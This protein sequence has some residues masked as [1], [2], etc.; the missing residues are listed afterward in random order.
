MKRIGLLPVVLC[1]QACLLFF[2]LDLL[3]VWT[4]ELFTLRT[5]AHPVAEIVPIVQHDIHPPLYYVLLHFWQ[6]LMPAESGVAPLRAFSVVWALLGTVLLDLFWAKKLKPLERSLAL[7][8]FALSPCLLLYGR[9]ARSY[10][11]QTALVLLAVGLIG[12]WMRAPRSIALAGGALASVLVLLYTHYAPGLAVLAG[13]VLIGWRSVGWMRMSVFALAVAA[14]YGPWVMGLGAA[15]GRWGGAGSFSARYALTGSLLLEHI[16]KIGFGLVSLT[17]GETFLGLSL[18]L[19]P[20]MLVL[21]LAGARKT[22]FSRAS[23]AMVGIAALAG[24]IGVSRW[25]SYPFIPARL[26]WF[27][28]FLCL[29][30]ACGIASLKR[31]T[32]RWGVVA[33]LLLS[34]AASCV[35]YF[36]REN[37]LNHGY[38]VPLPEIAATINHEGLPGDLILLDAYN[39][40]HQALAAQLSRQTPYIVLHEAGAA[41][42]L[43]RAGTA[44]TVWIVRNTRDGSPGQIT[45]KVQSAACAGRPERDRE[46]EP[47]PPWQRAM[48]QLAGMKPVPANYYEVAACGPVAPREADH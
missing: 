23:L 16:L 7:A 18:L 30:V 14:G 22:G 34:H 40:D 48:M 10:S 3:P 35:L 26:L 24:Y 41:D 28:P 20:V 1:L 9:M 15:V 27:L 31:P 5:V 12:L 37:F 21:A 38:S 39:T 45:T 19:V 36:R 47:Y 8:L 32:A 2:A 4:D 46:F 17:I 43:D 6:R 11:M 13:F 42:A 33:V 25:V 44:G 29:L